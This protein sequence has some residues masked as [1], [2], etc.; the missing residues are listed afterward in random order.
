[1]DLKLFRQHLL[2]LQEAKNAQGLV[3]VKNHD[4]GKLVFR[5]D[6][7]KNAPLVAV[8]SASGEAYVFKK[9][10]PQKLGV[11]K[12]EQDLLQTLAKH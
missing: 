4:G 10:T 5:G 9:G 7:K 11:F 3:I 2:K 12:D 8:V 6:P 1:M